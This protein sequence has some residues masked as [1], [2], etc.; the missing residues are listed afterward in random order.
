[1]KAEDREK[2]KKIMAGM[3]CP[4]NFICVESG[5]EHLCSAKDFGLEE[6]LDCL[7]D[8]PSSCSFAFPFGNGH[9]CECP[10]RV[11]ICKKLKR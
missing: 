11:Y 1:L 10:L 9:W 6:Y 7:E 3:Q 4:K 2:I 5:F 8:N